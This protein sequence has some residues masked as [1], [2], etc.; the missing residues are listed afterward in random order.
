MSERDRADRRQTD[1]GREK[2]QHLLRATAAT[3][4]SAREK[5]VLVKSPPPSRICGNLAGTL[6]T[7]AK[8][9]SLFALSGGN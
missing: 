6:S 9:L 1:R 7:L 3:E 2:E 8:A 5:S 4:K